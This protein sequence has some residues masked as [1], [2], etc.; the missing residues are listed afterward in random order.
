M[1]KTILVVSALCLWSVG[2]MFAEPKE[3]KHHGDSI[4]CREFRKGCPP[5]TMGMP[6]G[7]CR[8]PPKD[9]IPRGE[10]KKDFEKR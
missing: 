8:R 10:R 1:R 7:D 5:D 3:G 9:S 2:T 4:H 6:K